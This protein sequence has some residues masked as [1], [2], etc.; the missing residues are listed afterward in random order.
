MFENLAFLLLGILIGLGVYSGQDTT[1]KEENLEQKKQ[2]IILR[3]I[4][5]DYER[6]YKPDFELY[7]KM[8]QQSQ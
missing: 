3:K 7:K 2:E 1:A 8:Y 5:E 4:Q 6:G